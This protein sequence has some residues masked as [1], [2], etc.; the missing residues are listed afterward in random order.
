MSAGETRAVE[1]AIHAFVTLIWQPGDVREVRLPKWNGYQTAAGWFADPATLAHA[2]VAYDGKANIYVSV[3]PCAAGLLARVN[4]RIAPKQDTTTADAHI[5]RRRWLF[6]DI[7][8]TRADNVAGIAST[9]AE[10]TAA[11]AVMAAVASHLAGRGWPEPIVA[12]SGN[13]F[14][15]LYAIDLP[16]DAASDQLLKRVLAALAAQ[17]NTAAAHV[18]TTAANASRLMA[19]IGTLKAK[20]DGTSDRPR[21]RSFVESAPAALL[22]VSVDQLD[23]VAAEAPPP[24]AAAPSPHAAPQRTSPRPSRLA[25]L[26]TARGIAY[27]EQEPD[28]NGTTWYHLE[29]CPFHD[30]GRPFECGVGQTLPDGPFAGHCFHNRGAGKGWRDFKDRL[31]LGPLLRSELAGDLPEE[32]S[33]PA[34]I[35]TIPALPREAAL[36]AAACEA[37][38]NVRA[39]WLDAFIAAAAALSPRTPPSLLEACGIFALMLVI[40]RRCYVQTGPKR[41]FPAAF[42]IFVGRSTIRAKTTALEVLRQ[43]LQECGLNDLLLPSSFTPQALQADLALQLPAKIQDA[44]PLQQARWLARH[45]HGACRGIVRDEVSG[46]LEDCSKDYNKGLLPLLLKLDG[47]PSHVEADLTISRGLVEVE[48]VCINLLGATTPVAFREHAQQPHHWLNGLFSRFALIAADTE[49]MWSFWQDIEHVPDDVKWGLLALY[50]AFPLPQIAFT[51]A[52][53]LDGS[54]TAQITGVDQTAATPI[55]ATFAP[56]AWAAYERYDHA[57]FDLA[58]GPDFPERL[59]PTYGRLPTLAVRLAL[60]LACCSWAQSDAA[61]RSDVPTIELGH[62]AAAQAIVERWRHDAHR[63]LASALEDEAQEASAAD[64]DRLI[65][66]LEESGPTVRSLVLQGL[67]WKATRLDLALSAAAGRVQETTRATGG[68][69]ATALEIVP[70]AWPP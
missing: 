69:P 54:P 3:N 34:P 66:F 46:L 37:A 40:A 2:A 21:R 42:I 5:V 63:I 6:L 47:A 60:A 65:A 43:V 28:A 12:M 29:R 23:A 59:D 35:A 36:N 11:R 26:L 45:L 31:G 48:D 27:R 19:L 9:D 61:A 22:P 70:T 30:D 32:L 55:S 38:Q 1:E 7:D 4:S 41:Q 49:P 51:Y 13:G 25:D 58:K 33:A 20:G 56:A 18:D 67:R 8:A 17:F 44:S 57:L 50:D 10:L 53:G 64:S 52:E 39:V 14:Y 16:N 15:L 62:V 24:A 68:R